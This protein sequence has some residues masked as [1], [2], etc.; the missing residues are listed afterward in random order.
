[1]YF[2]GGS[3]EFNNFHGLLKN[4]DGLQMHAE[5]TFSSPK[6]N[7]WGISDKNLFLEANKTFKQQKA[8]FAIIQT[9][10]NHRPF[11]IPAG[12]QMILKRSILPIDTLKKYGFESVNEFNSFRY[13]DYCFKKFI[14]AAKKNPIFTIQFLFLLAIMGSRK[15]NG[16]VSFCMDGAAA[17]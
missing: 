6:M 9:A 16:H 15:C 17:K 10:D 3:P 11:M 13:S 12:R 4:I 14:E 1:M 7:V 5:G 8:F 2:L